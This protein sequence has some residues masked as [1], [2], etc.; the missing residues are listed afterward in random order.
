MVGVF[1]CS[2]CVNGR[3]SIFSAAVGLHSLLRRSGYL[4]P[5]SKFD[6]DLSSLR[7][8]TSSKLARASGNELA[9]LL[10]CVLTECVLLQDYVASLGARNPMIFVQG[11]LWAPASCSS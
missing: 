3:K 8:I 9:I 10:T 7:N 11:C 6:S 1:T 2:A 4:K 5:L